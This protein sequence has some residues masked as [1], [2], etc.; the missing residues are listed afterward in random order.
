MGSGLS[1]SNK[2]CDHGLGLARIM[3][4][5]GFRGATKDGVDDPNTAA[6]HAGNVTA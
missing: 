1:R 6:E 5:R 2:D 3:P 4:H